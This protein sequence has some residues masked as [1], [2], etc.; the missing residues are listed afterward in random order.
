METPRRTPTRDCTPLSLNTFPTHLSFLPEVREFITRHTAYNK[1]RYCRYTSVHAGLFRRLRLQLGSCLRLQLGSCLRLQLGELM[2]RHSS[3]ENSG[4][5][6]EFTRRTRL[7][8][9]GN[10]ITRIRGDKNQRLLTHLITC[11]LRTDAPPHTRAPTACAT[12]P[13]P[14]ADPDSC[15]EH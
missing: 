7:S 10:C 8:G 6:T 14:P 11:C 1:T 9:C 13:L 4:C 5:S 2:L 12:P 15:V 3:L